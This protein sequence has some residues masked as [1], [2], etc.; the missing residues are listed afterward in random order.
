MDLKLFLHHA[1]F[2]SHQIDRIHVVSIQQKSREWLQKTLGSVELKHDLFDHWTLQTAIAFIFQEYLDTALSKSHDWDI[3]L[4]LEFDPGYVEELIHRDTFVC[5]LQAGH[6]Y[7]S[8]QSEYAVHECMATNK[9]A[10][11]FLN[12]WTVEQAGKYLKKYSND[13]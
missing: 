5:N 6:Y 11:L 3:G 13:F 4:Y 9:L 8:I 2:K 10:A 12:E 1:L 7:R